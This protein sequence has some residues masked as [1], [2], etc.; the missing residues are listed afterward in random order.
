[1][2]TFLH[3]S[4]SSQ[5]IFLLTWDSDGSWAHFFLL[6]SAATC[7]HVHKNGS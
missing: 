7:V 5:V 1:M 6:L 2:D 3:L 4:K